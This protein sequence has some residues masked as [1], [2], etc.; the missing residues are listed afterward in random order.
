MPD[1]CPQG[2]AP[3]LY[4]LFFSQDK[5]QSLYDQNNFVHKVHLKL[6][7]LISKTLEFSNYKFII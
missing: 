1:M 5:F 7:T 4:L 3:E 2:A 6:S